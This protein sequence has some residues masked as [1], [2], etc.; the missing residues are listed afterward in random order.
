VGTED[1]Q[2]VSRSIPIA[3]RGGAQTWQKIFQIVRIGLPVNLEFDQIKSSPF[4]FIQ[5]FGRATA[6]PA[7]TTGT[8]SQLLESF[9]RS[10]AREDAKSAS[11]GD[12]R[13]DPNGLRRGQDLREKVPSTEIPYGIPNPERVTSAVDLGAAIVRR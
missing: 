1:R 10:A 5:G 4:E 8:S 3:R 11:S 6:V 12:I 2:I 7:L 13:L 9:G